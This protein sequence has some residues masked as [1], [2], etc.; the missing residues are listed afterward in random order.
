M[1]LPDR[2]GAAASGRRFFSSLAR[3]CSMPARSC[4]R[5]GPEAATAPLL[6]HHSMPEPSRLRGRRREEGASRRPCPLAPADH[7]ARVEQRQV[8]WEGVEME[9]GEREREVGCR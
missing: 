9:T 6:L 2:Q 4:H 5:P 8:G 3:S 1:E 7:L